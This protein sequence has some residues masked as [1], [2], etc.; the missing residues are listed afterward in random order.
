M[1]KA[2]LVERE[3]DEFL[4]KA[5]IKGSTL[6]TTINTLFDD[7]HKI[8]S[9]KEGRSNI[10]CRMSIL[11]NIP[12]NEQNPEQFGELFGAS[13]MTGFTSRL[14]FGYSGG[15]CDYNAIEDALEAQQREIEDNPDS[16]IGS[17]EPVPYTRVLKFND[18]AKELCRSY[19]PPEDTTNRTKYYMKKIAILTASADA[20][21][22]VDVEHVRAAI[23]FMDWQIRVKS[24]FHAND[25]EDC[26]A[27]RATATIMDALKRKTQELIDKGK[28]GD[29]LYIN[30]NRIKN[31]L[32][33]MKKFGASNYAREFDTLIRSGDLAY[34]VLV[35]GGEKNKPVLDKTLVKV[36]F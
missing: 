5:A 35:E 13:T 18:E 31:D 28:T 7:N 21:T 14:I 15:K 6:I 4:R 34:K 32:K 8:L 30:H 17:D 20:Q 9:S 3:F 25:G 16:L 10:D 26:I 22:I 1:K 36:N 19:D 29:D 2:L 27:S 12:V 11:G 33:W 24:V 23:A